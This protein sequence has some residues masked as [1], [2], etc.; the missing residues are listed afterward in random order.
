MLILLLFMF[1][2]SFPIA[3]ISSELIV[4]ILLFV[5]LIFNNKYRNTVL[6]IV[7]NKRVILIFMSLFAII[8]FS[9]FIPTL[10]LTYEYSI[11]RAFVARVVILLI[12]ILLYSFYLYK[13]SSEMILKNIIYVFII[14]SF[15]QLISFI[16]PEVKEILNI[17]RSES[18]IIIQENYGNIRGLAISG[19]AV[20]GLAIC[21][22]LIYIYYIIYWKDMFSNYKMLRLISFVL[23]LFGGLSAGRTA[24]IGIPI[25]LLYVVIMFF[26]KR[27]ITIKINSN[28]NIW[29]TFITCMVFI[30]IVVLSIFLL[31]NESLQYR[32]ETLAD[33]VLQFYYIY[34]KTGRL[35]TSSTDVLFS[36][37][38]FGVSTKTF[39]LGDGMYTDTN[40]SY[41]MNTDAGYM[42]NILF[43]G[44]FGVILLLIFQLLLFNWKSTS[45]V[46]EN[47]LIVLFILILHIKGDV[48][49]FASQL[50]GI[51]FIKFLYDLKITKNITTLKPND[52]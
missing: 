45:K 33:Y 51:L 34:E 35:A 13:D 30:G 14:Q 12:G 43:F 48:L 24:F 37:M 8:G 52:F 18:A 9:L 44:F 17:F 11:V 49:G 6:K 19:S 26:M 7:L 10:H 46:I 2:F 39:L 36:N 38:Y 27:R 29:N 41:Y 23:L 3:L 47:I 22:G 25:G 31:T 1:L 40:G 4:G 16:Y 32:L 20:F 15:I 28:F 5:L 21:Y 42:R 50:T